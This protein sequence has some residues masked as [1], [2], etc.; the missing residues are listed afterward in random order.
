MVTIEVRARGTADRRN[1]ANGRSVNSAAAAAAYT[2]TKR[3]RRA[4]GDDRFDGD[5]RRTRRRRPLLVAV[6]RRLA[7]LFHFLSH[8]PFC[9]QCVLSVSP[10]SECVRALVPVHGAV[11]TAGTSEANK[12]DSSDCLSTPS[13]QTR[14]LNE[15]T[16]IRSLS[17]HLSYTP[18]LSRTLSLTLSPS[19]SVFP[20]TVTAA[21]R[22]GIFF[23]YRSM[24]SSTR[25]RLPVY[26]NSVF[27]PSPSNRSPSH[28]NSH[29]RSLARLPPLRQQCP[30]VSTCVPLLDEPSI[31]SFR[32][33]MHIRATTR[34]PIPPHT[35]YRPYRLSA[36]TCA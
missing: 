6:G 3:R 21:N 11:I 24:R 27:T 5:G 33:P 29:A 14:S 16:P 10:R 17:N 4:G 22:C 19:L 32:A 20:A 26:Y 31:R 1:S 13:H 15:L 36:F 12:S 23:S 30:T 8:P 25:T 34:A 35:Y 18:S 2:C 9:R 7:K 28:R